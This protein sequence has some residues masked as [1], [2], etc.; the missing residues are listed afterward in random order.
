MTLTKILLS[1]NV[2]RGSAPLHSSAGG[3]VPFEVEVEA[4][5]AE[6][7]VE[8]IDPGSVWVTL[9]FHKRTGHRP[10]A[11]PSVGVDSDPQIAWK[12]G[13]PCHLARWCR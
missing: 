2:M 7:A 8:V 13:S 6:D 12:S 9:S 4:A 10:N 1:G 5:V 11:L 3:R